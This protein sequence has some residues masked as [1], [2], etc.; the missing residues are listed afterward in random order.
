MVV[1]SDAFALSI[2][3]MSEIASSNAYVAIAVA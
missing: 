1:D 3:S 2:F